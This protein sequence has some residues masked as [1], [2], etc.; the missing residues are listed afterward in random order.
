[1]SVRIL[2][3]TDGAVFYDS[4]DGLA[5]GPLMPDE[6][7][8]DEFLEHLKFD[9]RTYTDKD[10]ADE[11]TRFQRMRACEHDWRYDMEESI[12]KTASFIQRCTKCEELQ[13]VMR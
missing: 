3:G 5:F 7:T 4:T 13:E 10:I 6:A 8:A 9:A 1:M 12:D 2:A 11:W